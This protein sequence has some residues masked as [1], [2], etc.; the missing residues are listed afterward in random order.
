VILDVLVEM[1]RGWGDAT[2]G[3]KAH[4]VWALANDVL[5]LGLLG[6][7]LVL[8]VASAGPGFPTGAWLAL[9]A[10]AVLWLVSIISLDPVVDR[11]VYADHG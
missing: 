8:L 5:A 1:R 4:A 7:T 6:G 3:E 9:V 11:F 10:V 2:R